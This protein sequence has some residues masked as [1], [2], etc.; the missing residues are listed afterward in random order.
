M[1]V[2]GKIDS[3]LAGILTDN[4]ITRRVVAAGLVPRTT[5]VRDVMTRS[6]HTVRER[7]RET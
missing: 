5:P 6:P 1:L 4:D 2:V 7:E 3:G